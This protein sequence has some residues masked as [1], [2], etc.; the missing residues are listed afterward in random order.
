MDKRTC[1]VCLM[2]GHYSVERKQCD[3]CGCTDEAIMDARLITSPRID[4]S[5]VYVTSV[6]SK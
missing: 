6:P 3:F 1:P 4:N 5:S 2:R